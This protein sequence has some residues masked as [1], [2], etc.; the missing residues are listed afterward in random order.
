VRY[1]FPMAHAYVYEGEKEQGIEAALAYGEAVLGLAPKGNPDVIVFRY[2]L[3]SVDD[4]RRVKRLADM[5]PLHGNEKLLVV[6]AE[7]FFHEAQNAFLKLFE[8]PAPGTTLIL[9]VPSLGQ[10]RETLRSRLT[11]LPGIKTSGIP[12]IAKAFVEMSGTEREKYIA[13][14]LDRTKS[15]KD[16]EK[17]SARSEALQLTEGLMRVVYLERLKKESAEGTRFLADLEQF[18]PILHE[19]SAPLKLIF[20]HL[21]LTLPKSLK[22]V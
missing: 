22:V 14:L 12:E 10:L 5:S 9:V 17:Q 16:E 3:L 2:G 6:S 11:A 21:L 19:R 8:E 13:K 7:R 20:E 18:L 4:A 1:S 15:D